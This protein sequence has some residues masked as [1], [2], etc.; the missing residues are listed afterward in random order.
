MVMK[1]DMSI[2]LK[3][4]SMAFVFCDSFNRSPVFNL[5]LVIGTRTSDLDPLREVGAVFYVVDE[6]EFPCCL[7]GGVDGFGAATGAACCGAA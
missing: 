6:A 2:S 5:I 3:V 4:V 7:G 1:A